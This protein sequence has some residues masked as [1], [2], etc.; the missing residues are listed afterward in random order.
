MSVDPAHAARRTAKAGGSGAL[1]ERG[2]V[3]SSSDTSPECELHG[4]QALERV[5]RYFGRMVHVRRIHTSTH[6]RLPDS[7]NPRT[8]SAIPF[9]MRPLRYSINVTLDGC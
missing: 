8:P 3:E 6:G 7:R 2:S 9:R 5:A 4:W 1:G